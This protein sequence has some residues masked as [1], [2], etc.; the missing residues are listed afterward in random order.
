M[1]WILMLCL[2]DDGRCRETPT[3]IA[4][5]PAQCEA[6]LTLKFIGALCVTPN[7]EIIRGKKQ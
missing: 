5:S 2:T 3:V 6:V 1:S 7:G 4:V